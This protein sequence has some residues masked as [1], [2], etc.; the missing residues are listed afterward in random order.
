MKKVLILMF[1]IGLIFSLGSCNAQET[2]DS[3][4]S[5]KTDPTITVEKVE[6][7]YFHGTRRC[8]TCKA[9]GRVAQ[10]L[11]QNKYGNNKKVE[12]VEID[13]DVPGNEDLVEKFEVTSSGLY[14]YNGVEVINLTSLAFR[15]ATTDP[16]K[17]RDKL[18]ELIDKNL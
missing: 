11:V 14:V 9:V 16:D 17:L 13:Y 3:E 6:V 8:T 18:T 4:N 10:A 7:Y 1:S 5:E 2:K 12:F 15:Y